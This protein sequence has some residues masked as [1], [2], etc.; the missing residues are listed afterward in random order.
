[1]AGSMDFSS[2]QLGGSRLFCPTSNHVFYDD[3]C[4]GFGNALFWPK[5][6]PEPEFMDQ[7]FIKDWRFFSHSISLCGTYHQFEIASLVFWPC[8]I[9]I[10]RTGV[11]CNRATRF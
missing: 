2:N 5:A 1:M 7:A 4:A 9:K 11:G 8:A 3:L 6:S 10:I